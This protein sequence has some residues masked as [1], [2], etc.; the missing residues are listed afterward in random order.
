MS[1]ALFAPLEPFAAA[2]LDVGEGHRIFFEQ[3]GNPHGAPVLFLHGGPG[4]SINPSHRRFFDPAYYRV[5]LFDQRGCGRSTPK[6][7]IDANTTPKLV[8][9]I[10]LLRRY[11]GIAR[12]LLFG[13]SWGS[14]LGLAY[15][16]AHADAASGLILRGVFLGSREEVSWF[17]SGLRAFLPEAWDAFSRSAADKSPAGILQHYYQRIQQSDE[18]AASRWNAWENAVLAVGESA[19]APGAVD[20]VATLSRVKVNLHYLFHDC[21]LGPAELL[22]GI[23][24]LGSLPAIVVQGRRDLACPPVTAYTLCQSWPHSELRMV[25]D[26]GHIATNPSMARALVQATQDIK[27]RL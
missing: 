9:D 16:Q 22:H 12:W 26:G 18:T 10:E 7:E 15:A 1:D 20:P 17:L 2:W 14:A 24:R 3:C 27:Q 23:Q 13:G 5:I 4:S 8:E 19:S 25:E 6:G 11:L 21:F